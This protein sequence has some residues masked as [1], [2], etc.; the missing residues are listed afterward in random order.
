MTQ[1][2]EQGNKKKKQSQ[3]FLSLPRA[4]SPQ[5]LGLIYRDLDSQNQLSTKQ[6]LC[7][8]LTLP[9]LASD[10]RPELASITWRRSVVSHLAAVRHIYHLD[11]TAASNLM[12]SDFVTHP[13]TQTLVNMVGTKTITRPQASAIMLM[14]DPFAM[15]VPTNEENP[16]TSFLN[17]GELSEHE[18]AETQ[19]PHDQ[20]FARSI[21]VEKLVGDIIEGSSLS[22][23]AQIMAQLMICP[24]VG[25]TR[26]ASVLSRWVDTGLEGSPSQITA[27]RQLGSLVDSLLTSALKSSDT[28]STPDQPSISDFDALCSSLNIDNMGTPVQL[29]WLMF[30]NDCPLLLKV[31]CWLSK[32]FPSSNICSK[33]TAMLLWSLS[34]IVQPQQAKEP[35]LD[36]LLSGTHEP[37]PASRPTSV[38]HDNSVSGLLLLQQTCDLLIANGSK[39]TPMSPGRD[40]QIRLTLSA[41]M[42]MIITPDSTE[43]WLILVQLKDSEVDRSKQPILFTERMLNRPYHQVGLTRSDELHLVT[44]QLAGLQS[45]AM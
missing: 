37:Q 27:Q 38:Y 44:Y 7:V 36:L 22:S 45:I 23:E 31:Y 16:P 26:S 42:G 12:N 32:S 11:A 10:I 2:Y 35:D 3:T 24:T 5:L 29:G 40:D 1:K 41:D 28:S 15:D 34:L 20:N 14:G 13:T 18:Y 25:I 19:M 4:L 17:E 30:A 9:V 6:R 21:E 39:L 8:W 33:L 43:S